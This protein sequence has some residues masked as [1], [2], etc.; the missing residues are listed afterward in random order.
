MMKNFDELRDAQRM[1]SDS[2]LI[3]LGTIVSPVMEH[4]IISRHFVYDK[5]FHVVLYPSLL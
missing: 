3:R 4:C 1:T 5:K 2:F